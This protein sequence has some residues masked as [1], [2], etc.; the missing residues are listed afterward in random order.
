[1]EWENNERERKCVENIN[2][3]NRGEEK[4]KKKYSKV[5]GKKIESRK[6]V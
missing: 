6:C 4:K 5:G 3:R 1:M 2:Y